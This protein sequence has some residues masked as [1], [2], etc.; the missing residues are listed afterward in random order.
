LDKLD[1]KHYIV[2][3]HHRMEKKNHYIAFLDILGFKDLIENNQLDD[4]IKL[5][6]KFEPSLLYS[7][8]FTNLEWRSK[9]LKNSDLPGLDNMPLN[10]LM[11][12]DSIL[13]WTDSDSGK[14][15][16]QLLNTVKYHFQLAL[17]YGVPLRGAITF[18]EL[19]IKSGV[20]EKS[21]KMNGFSTILGKPLTK[22]YILENQAEW[23]GCIVDQD[24]IDYYNDYVGD[25]EL[26]AD[27]EFLEQ[28]TM[29]KRYK[30]PMKSGELKEY[31][32]VNWTT[33]GNKRVERDSI[34]KS[35]SKHSKRVNN[36]AVE[37]KILNT[38]R[39]FDETESD[40]ENFVAFMDKRK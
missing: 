12:S 37:T 22:A 16:I 28:M 32:T 1:L 38:L 27:T 26:P 34:R 31:Y 6:D 36:W 11:I 3:A 33:F 21:N 15:F 8:A 39:Y 23:S 10:S 40:H 19:A 5:Y 18:G 4:V 17:S 29:L 14:D 2:V 25:D 24:C 9:N 30:V 13:I 7:M 35:F 20:H